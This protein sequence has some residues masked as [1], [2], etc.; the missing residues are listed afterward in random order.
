MLYPEAVMVATLALTLL[1]PRRT[2]LEREFHQKC[3]HTVAIATL[4]GMATII[5]P[6]PII[7]NFIIIIISLS[8]SQPVKE[9]VE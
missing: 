1:P 9:L 7:I 2:T 4:G 5:I 6:T 3:T 8:L